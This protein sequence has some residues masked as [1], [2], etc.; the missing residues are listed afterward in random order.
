MVLKATDL[1]DPGRRGGGSGLKPLLIRCRTQAGSLYYL[2]TQ[3]G[4]PSSRH[5]L[6]ARPGLEASLDD[7]RANS[8]SSGPNVSSGPW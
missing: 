4:T 7:A 5:M 6:A 2:R 1:D 3:A 8:R